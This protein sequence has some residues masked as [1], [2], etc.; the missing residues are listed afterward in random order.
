MIHNKFKK[1]KI[2]FLAC[3]LLF[4]CKKEDCKT[5]EEGLQN[6]IGTWEGSLELRTF[7]N[8]KEQPGTATVGLTITILDDN[9]GFYRN[10]FGITI[11]FTW[12]YTLIPEEALLLTYGGLE[13]QSIPPLKSYL[14]I[15]E[16]SLNKQTWI[17]R[18]P[19]YF[20][21]RSDWGESVTKWVLRK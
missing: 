4:S 12:S 17:E 11:P 7:F 6:L 9:K 2:L 20:T 3:L 18:T 15:E 14:L 21:D 16:S 8:S 13:N 10:E 19:F 5:Y 1:I